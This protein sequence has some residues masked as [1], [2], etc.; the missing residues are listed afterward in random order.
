MLFLCKVSLVENGSRRPIL[1]Y[2]TV[3]HQ[4]LL[5]FARFKNLGWA[6]PTARLRDLKL[7]ETGVCKVVRE[8]AYSTSWHPSKDKLLL[9]VGD[10]VASGVGRVAAS[11]GSVLY[12]STCDGSIGHF[13]R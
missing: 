3:V 1:S 4:I 12:S 13:F 7:G 11:A 5:S 10:K 6:A 8:R 2:Y 9:A